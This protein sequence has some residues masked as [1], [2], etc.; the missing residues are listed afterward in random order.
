MAKYEIKMRLVREG[1][2]LPLN[3]GYDPMADMKAHSSSLK[4]PAVETDTYL[5]RSQLEEL[6]RLQQ[7]RTELARRKVLGLEHSKDLGVRKEDQNKLY[8]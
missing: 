2:T 3:D 8:R 6:R 5:N 7:E 1:E 4:R